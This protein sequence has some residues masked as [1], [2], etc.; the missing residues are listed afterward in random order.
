MSWIHRAIVAE[1]VAL[2]A[3]PLASNAQQ[4]Y[5]C[6]NTY[7]QTP[8]A[9]DAKAARVP[10]GAAPDATPGLRGKDLCVSEGPKLLRFPDPES[11]RF[12]PVARGGAQVI[13]YADK[14]TVA[15]RYDMVI[16]TKN[17]QGA[18]T[19]DALYAC[20]VSEDQSRILK[21]EARR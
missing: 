1:L 21:V 8:C 18:Y 3:A 9:P 17:T 4:L 2:C 16:N 12:G 6:G 11:T 14:P 19:G 15:Q 13:Q 20:F 5:R 7:S 10:S